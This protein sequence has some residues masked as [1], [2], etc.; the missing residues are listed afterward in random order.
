[1]KKKLIILCSTQR[2]GSTMIVSDFR[3]TNKLG[4][5]EE[6]F[7]PWKP[8][9]T[10][11]WYKAYERILQTSSTENGV[12][13]IKVMANQLPS[14]ESCLKA[15]AEVAPEHTPSD[16]TYLFP[17]VREAFKNAYFIRIRR[18]N[19]NHCNC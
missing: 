9:T 11:D 14:I 10:N 5:P 7:I 13:C 6:Y 8:D 2:C 12:S 1:M 3:S 17:H 16:K 18:G 4:L 19:R 15:T